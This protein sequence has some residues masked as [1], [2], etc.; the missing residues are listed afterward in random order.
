M[1]YLALAFLVTAS[2]ATLLAAQTT[3]PRARVTFPDGT[4]VSVEIADTEAS[5]ARGLMFRERLAPNE[6]MIFVFDRPGIYPFYMKNTLIPLDMLWLD[7]DGRV[8]SVARSVPPC[9]ADPCPSYYPDAEA[10]YVVEVVAGFTARHNVNVGDR[11][12]IDGLQKAGDTR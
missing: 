3:V 11:L 5:R 4:R 1:R 6:G 10:I 12:K 9:K 8:V 7:A 2:L